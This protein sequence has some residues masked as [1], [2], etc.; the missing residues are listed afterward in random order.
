MT[1]KTDR[2]EE[3]GLR[4][5]EEENNKLPQAFLDKKAQWERADEEQRLDSLYSKL[6]L[7]R[8]G[9][10]LQALVPF[11]RERIAD[12]NNLIKHRHISPEA[13]FQAQMRQSAF[14]EIE[15]FIN[16]YSDLFNKGK[17]ETEEG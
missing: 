5:I 17:E 3:T 9:I 11:I 8:D 16:N 13:K 14:Q 4:L 12:Y 7:T 1:H 6:Q 10:V 2:E 15:N